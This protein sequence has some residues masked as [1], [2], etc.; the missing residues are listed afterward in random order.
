MQAAWTSP[1][2]AAEDGLQLTWCQL[3][4]PST[5]YTPVYI[6]DL[7]HR[8]IS[9]VNIS[10]Q[11]FFLRYIQPLAHNT[12][13]ITSLLIIAAGRPISEGLRLLAGR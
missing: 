13:H 7:Y 2:P 5:L 10:D 12:L 9:L 3:G 6:T 4:D 8:S 1:Q 11:L